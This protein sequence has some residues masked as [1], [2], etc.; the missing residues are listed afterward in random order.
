MGLFRKLFGNTKDHRAPVIEISV[1]GPEI[2]N[3]NRKFNF[4]IPEV[5]K[6]PK[7]EVV[8]AV[9]PPGPSYPYCPYCGVEVEPPPQRQRRCPHCAETFKVRTWPW[10]D[11]KIL[12]TESQVELVE[13]AWAD[14]NIEQSIRISATHID[15]TDPQWDRITQILTTEWGAQPSTR[16]IFWRAASIQLEKRGVREDWHGMS[17]IYREMATVQSLIGSDNMLSLQLANQVEAEGHRA[18]GWDELVI[19][20]DCC[21]PCDEDDQVSIAVTS[22]IDS[23][24]L[25]HQKCE[26][27]QCRC[28]YGAN[29]M[30]D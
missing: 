21:E 6:L 4:E 14:R 20:A 15:V 11:E 9:P 18:G 5:Q 29:V 12:I 23:N 27:E 22:A 16:D 17:Q 3:H 28:F 8:N 13:Q 2:S 30:R 24:R 1:T 25:P 26:R 7:S 19:F 10:T